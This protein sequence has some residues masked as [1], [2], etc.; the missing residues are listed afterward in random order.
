MVTLYWW[1]FI[2]RYRQTLDHLFLSVGW[3]LC[4]FTGLTASVLCS[5]ITTDTPPCGLLLGNHNAHPSILLHYGK[6]SAFGLSCMTAE[7][8]NTG[9]KVTISTHTGRFFLSKNDPRKTV[10]LCLCRCGEPQSLS[11]LTLRSRFP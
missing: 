7:R 4:G 6:Q 2:Q 10:S 5:S 8:I 3:M 1:R 11:V 9:H